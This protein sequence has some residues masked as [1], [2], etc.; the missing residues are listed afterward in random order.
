MNRT[1]PYTTHTGLQIGVY[2]RPAYR[3]PEVSEDA[4]R[5]QLALLQSHK[6]PSCKADACQQGAKPCATPDQCQHTEDA[7][8]TAL[9]VVLWLIGAACA[10]LAAIGI[11]Q[12]WPAP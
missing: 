8:D 10:V 2:W 6:P 9:G 7:A 11:A 1:V 3:A 12:T 4:E 5:L